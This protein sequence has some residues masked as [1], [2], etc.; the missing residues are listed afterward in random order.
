MFLG[1]DDR[2]DE[3]LEESGYFEKRWKTRMEKIDDQSGYVRSIRI[4]IRH[5][6]HVTVPQTFGIGIRATGLQSENLFERCDFGIV[7]DGRRRRIANVQQFPTKRE[8]AIRIPTYDAQTRDRET[9]GR[10]SFGQYQRAC[11]ASVRPGPIR[12]GQFRD[13]IDPSAFDAIGFLERPFVDQRRFDD[14]LGDDGI[15]DRRHG[16]F[17]EDVVHRNLEFGR[18][19]FFGLGI[20]RRIDHRCVDEHEHVVFDRRRFDHDFFLEGRFDDAS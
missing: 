15:Q 11:I 4:R 17:D 7:G 5:D 19:V 12:I 18:Q 9:F 1:P 3:T 14:R 6:H 16:F 20:E 10:I 8:D 13:T 2:R